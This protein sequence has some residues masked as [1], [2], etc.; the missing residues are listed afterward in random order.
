MAKL[1]NQKVK[2]LFIA[3]YIIR[4]SDEDHGFYI[5]DLKEHLESKG[6]IAEYHSIT[7]DIKLLRDQFG[8]DIDGGG[9]R[10][11]PFYLLSRHFPFEDIST[12]AECIGSAQ[13]LSEGEA[14]K[15]TETLKGFCSEHQAKRIDKDYFVVGRPRRTQE[16]LLATLA[17]IRDAIKENEKITFKYT[18]RTLKGF[19]KTYRRKGEDYK[20]SPFQV[21]L[22]EGNH[23]LIGYNDK[24]KRIV[25][26]RVSRMDK[27]NYA[28]EPRDG[29]DKFIR[30]GIS[31]Y[32]RQTFGMFIGP[33]AKRITLRCD[34]DLLDTMIER[35]GTTKSVEYRKDGED[36]FTITT[37][38]VV[39]PVFYGWICG[40][41]GKAVIQ[42][43]GEEDSVA[44]K[45]L[46]YLKAVREK[47]QETME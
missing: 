34:N 7:D 46:D 2:L 47:Q 44:K 13:F 24:S 31:D 35:F 26:Y 45:Y 9:G 5:K 18:T 6:I 14:K 39:S 27:V 10:G 21:V 11:R 3:D 29:E 40:L 43:S 41:G 42:D 19:S 12:I 8:M 36:H 30:M 32:A 33:K 22:S 38:I 4:N 1:S 20:V 15:L 23:Y 37:A 17:L 28:H 25:S 16:D